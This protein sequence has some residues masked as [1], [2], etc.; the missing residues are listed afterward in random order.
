MT[1][2]IDLGAA[3]EFCEDTPVAKQAG[4]QPLAVF[5]LG[6]ERAAPLRMSISP[7]CS[8]HSTQP[9]ST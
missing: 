9:S 8:G 4:G 6:A 5:R 1:T 3:D 7:W 2:W